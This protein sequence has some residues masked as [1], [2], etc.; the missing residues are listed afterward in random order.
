MTVEIA[1]A[2]ARGP[3]TW[4]AGRFF[5]GFLQGLRAPFDGLVYLIGHRDLWPLAL[6]PFLVGLAI[7]VVILLG[8]IGA[9]AFLIPMIDHVAWFSADWVGRVAEALAMLCV[10]ATLL[11]CAAGA[12]AL[13]TGIFTGLA[14]ERLARQVE[15]Q[16]GM[17]ADQLVLSS[18]KEQVV[19]GALDF[20]A[21]AGTAA[22]TFVLGCIPVVGFFAAGLNFYLD[23]YVLGSD[24]LHI[25]VT[26]RRGDKRAFTR[27]HRPETLGLGAMV[28]GLNF[29]PVVGNLL[30]TTAVIGAVLLHRRLTAGEAGGASRDVE[31]A[32]LR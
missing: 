20:L 27:K 1:A 22:G 17:R 18:F 16:L 26:L 7:T 14:N 9:A 28:L 3:G 4:R 24:F 15:I 31:V 23:C 2:R 5:A 12:Y 21:V 32:S 25:P 11:A 30:L 10:V 6:A 19:D 13:A 8:L 29:V